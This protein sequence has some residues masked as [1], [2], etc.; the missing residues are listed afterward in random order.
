MGRRTRM[1]FVK[2]PPNNFYFIQ[3]MDDTLYDASIMLTI[4]EFEAMRLKHYVSLTQK[5]S[6]DRMGVSQP[7]FSRI[8]E[9]AHQKVTQA[10]V[11]GKNIK[12]FGG[13][14]NY[15]K[16]FL[17]Y[18]CLNCEHEWEDPQAS[19]ERKTKCP[20]CGS[21]SVYFLVKNPL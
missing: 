8:L 6:A 20:K 12:I 15:K 18:G 1:R 5:D 2:N 10:F 14:I 21:S 9:G 17:G 11:E 7:T 4:A 19:Q 16:P 13:N 3:R